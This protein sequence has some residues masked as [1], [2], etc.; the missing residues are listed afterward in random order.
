MSPSP[1]PHALVTGASSG[2]GAAITDRLLTDGWRVTALSRTEPDQGHP[3]LTWRPVDLAAPAGLDQAIAAALPGNAPLDA[4]V[5]AAGM[6]AS[7]P[8]GELNAAA[9]E[10][11][12]RVHVQAA[13]V[14]LDALLHRI[15]DGGRIVLLGSRT[16]A[17]VPGKSQYAATKAALPALARAWA[18][19][20]APRAITVNV[21]APGPTDTP[22]LHDPARAATPP[23]T[24]ALG[25]LVRPAEVAALTAFLLGPDGGSVTGQQ[26]VMCGGASLAS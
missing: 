23:R 13:T 4:V 9:G 21:V 11:M 17:G 6:Q 18:A 19:E 16:A 20:L 3:A 1:P 25:R 14:L 12:W 8:L 10:R 2:I 15:P 5:H 7:A 22:M 26:L 24:P